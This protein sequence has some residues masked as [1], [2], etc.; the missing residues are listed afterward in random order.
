[1][2][3]NTFNRDTWKSFATVRLIETV[4]KKDLSHFFPI[5]GRFNRNILEFFATV[6]LHA[7][8]DYK[9]RSYKKQRYWPNSLDC[10][11]LISVESAVTQNCVASVTYKKQH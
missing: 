9:K 2:N 11:D 8:S 1:M 10:T 4:C 3:G 7:V 5:H 6:R